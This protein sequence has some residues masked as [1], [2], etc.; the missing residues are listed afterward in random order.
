MFENYC[1]KALIRYLYLVFTLRELK[2]NRFITIKPLYHHKN[3]EKMKQEGTGL[4]PM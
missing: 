4:S 3:K 1:L 2:Y